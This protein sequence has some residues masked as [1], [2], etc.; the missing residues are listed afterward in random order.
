MGC[1]CCI[2]REEPKSYEV[3]SPRSRAGTNFLAPVVLFV[4]E[5]ST[6]ARAF[7]NASSLRSRT[8]DNDPIP[9]PTLTW[10]TSRD[11]L[12]PLHRTLGPGRAVSFCQS[13]TSESWELYDPEVGGD[14]ALGALLPT[15][16]LSTFLR[17]AP[18][19]SASSSIARDKNCS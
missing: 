6:R 7:S 19:P 5:H 10:A 11:G 8:G 16:P 15:L 18:R 2:K 1:G 13:Q 9:T 17:A 12:S 14:E 4:D 3:N